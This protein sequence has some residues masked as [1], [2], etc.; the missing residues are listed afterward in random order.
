VD[1]DGLEGLARKYQMVNVA[2]LRK[3]TYSDD[4]GGLSNSTV[5]VPEQGGVYWGNGT[6]R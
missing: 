1:E 6:H 4:N 2:A 5:S 3:S